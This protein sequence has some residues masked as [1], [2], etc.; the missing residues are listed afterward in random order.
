M[1]LLQQMDFLEASHKNFDMIFEKFNS[2]FEAVEASIQAWGST[3]HT[4]STDLQKW[5]LH[6][7]TQSK[8][9]SHTDL[10]AEITSLRDQLSSHERQLASLLNDKVVLSTDHS[11]LVSSI[12]EK[13]NNF[14]NALD[15]V[16]T[17]K[18]ELAI[19]K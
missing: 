15:D 4:Y 18:A 10:Q 7:A 11:S 17:C 16:N 14:Q 5:L 2:R 9:D 12:I 1:N 3:L 8:A 19:S 13:V 6:N